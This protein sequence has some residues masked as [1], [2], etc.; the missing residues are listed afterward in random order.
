M[1]SNRD[2]S[3]RI[4]KN[5]AILY[6]RMFFLMLVN[7]YTSRV[8]LDALGVKDY[9]IYNV[10]GG[11]V[12][13]FA[14][15]SS[16]LT[17]ACT[18][19]LN[20]EMGIGESDRQMLVFSTSVI[21]QFILAVVIFVLAEIVGIWYINNMMVIPYPR[22]IAAN[23]CFQFSVFSFCM[24]LIC[25]PYNATIIAHEKMRAFAYVSIGQ[26][27]AILGVSFAIYYEPFDRLI[28]YALLLM[29]V[30]LC[31]LISYR[32]YCKNNFHEC[33]ICRAFD[34]TLLHNMLS[35][36]FWHLIGNGATVLKTHGVNLVLNLFGGP[37][38]NAARGLATQVDNAVNQFSGNFMMAINPQIT[39]SYAKGDIKYM[40]NLVYKGSY[41]S[42]YLIFLLSL[43]IMINSKYLMSLWLKE[44]PEYTVIFTQLALI[45]TVIASL[46][47]PLVTAQNA[48]GNVRNYQIAIGGIQL[49]NLPLSY[50]ALWLGYSP[51]IVVVAIIVEFVSFL[52]RIFMLPK[53]LLYF[54]PYNYLKNVGFK[55]LFVAI[56]A[57]PIP[58]LAFVLLEEGFLSLF[59]NV[60]ICLS[61]CIIS[62]LFVGCDTNERNFFY[63]KIK[64]VRNKLMK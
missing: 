1:N 56:C 49:L 40:L 7:L 16:A 55:C 8:V 46:S 33:R 60:I 41:F 36:S 50:L 34:K 29:V 62:V 58:I 13:M 53:T 59:V 45:V 37:T 5:T 51:F 35:Y 15:I 61:C 38:V 54:R 24:N 63:S 14:L 6:F 31:I 57:A 18:R 20:Y 32:I 11:F 10:V 21:I 23:W 48:T 42:F 47:R 12:A 19:F 43:P 22:L 17:S 2:K 28:F 25:V 44:V 52:A 39:Q 64:E 27:I 3:R 9:G 26:G 30:Q 4:A